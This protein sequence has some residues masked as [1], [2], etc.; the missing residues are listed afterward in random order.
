MLLIKTEKQLKD[1]ISILRKSGKKINF[2][3]TMGN[4]HSGHL[5]LVKKAKKKTMFVW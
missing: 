2:V 5:S 1:E 4:L 3:P